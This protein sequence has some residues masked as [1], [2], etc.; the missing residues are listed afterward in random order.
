[1]VVYLRPP[2]AE[3]RAIV[4]EHILSSNAVF[5]LDT[6]VQHYMFGSSKLPTVFVPDL[7]DQLDG[8]E[9]EILTD[10]PLDT[11]D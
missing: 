10:E 7:A 6:L 5:F 1:M 11:G 8:L 2:T 3:E 9:E 4:E